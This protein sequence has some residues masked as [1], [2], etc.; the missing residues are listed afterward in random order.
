MQLAKGLPHLLRLRRQFYRDVEAGCPSA[1]DQHGGPTEGNGLAVVV[2]VNLAPPV[3]L[4]PRQLRQF[5]NRIVAEGPEP[6]S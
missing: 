4:D 1:E 6:R 3:P 2:A 5:G